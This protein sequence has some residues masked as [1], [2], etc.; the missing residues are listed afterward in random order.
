MRGD[1]ILGTGYWSMVLLTAVV[2]VN[3]AIM[4]DCEGTVIWCRCFFKSNVD[5]DGCIRYSISKP[6]TYLI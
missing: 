5:D 2:H 1:C 3:P 4:S 6:A